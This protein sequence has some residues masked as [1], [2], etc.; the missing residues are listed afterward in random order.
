VFWYHSCWVGKT[1][2]QSLPL[3]LSSLCV[4]PQHEF[5]LTALEESN[6]VP[7]YDSE[8]IDAR[9]TSKRHLHTTPRDGVQTERSE[10]RALQSELNEAIAFSNLPGAA[11]NL[12]NSLDLTIIQKV[13][14]C[15]EIDG[16]QKAW[17]HMEEPG[18]HPQILWSWPKQRNR[19]SAHL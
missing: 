1:R 18:N 11:S 19:R 9:T 5:L 13:M 6:P 14:G 17:K 3:L 16:S 8:S 10:E 15:D 2:F 7:E 4:Q 12:P